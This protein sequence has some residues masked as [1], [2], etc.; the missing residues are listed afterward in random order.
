MRIGRID[1]PRQ[2]VLRFVVTTVGNGK[3]DSVKGLSERL[4]HFENDVLVIVFLD[5]GEIQVG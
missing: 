5:S 4:H 1:A 2:A 3:L